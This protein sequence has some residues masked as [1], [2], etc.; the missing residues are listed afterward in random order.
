MKEIKSFS[1]N[2]VG[3]QL[4]VYAVNNFVD[5]VLENVKDKIGICP[6]WKFWAVVDWQRATGFFIVSMDD[7]IQKLAKEIIPGADKKA[8]VLA[9]LDKAYDVIIV[10][11][12]PIWLKPLVIPAKK[13]I[14][15]VVCSML[16]DW[17]VEKYKDG[18]WRMNNEEKKQEMPIA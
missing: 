4:N 18:S 7:L 9:A 15:N 5:T 1:A 12:A 6:W 3:Q 11:A 10:G 14:I 16:I 17:F 8:T 13:L 2:P